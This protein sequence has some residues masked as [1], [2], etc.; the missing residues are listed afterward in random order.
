MKGGRLREGEGAQPFFAM[1]YSIA[2]ELDRTFARLVTIG[3]TS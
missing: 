1:L 2:H 3:N